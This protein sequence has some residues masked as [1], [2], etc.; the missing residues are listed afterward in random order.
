LTLID[1]AR[2]RVRNI[3]NKDRFSWLD[4]DRAS[5]LRLRE[6][7]TQ[8]YPMTGD[9]TQLGN[10][11]FPNALFPILR[12]YPVAISGGVEFHIDFEVELT[13]V[14]PQQIH[15]FEVDAKSVEWF[16]SHYGNRSDFLINHLGLSS[17]AEQLDVLGDINRAW[18]STVDKR[19]A[20]SS[21]QRWDVI[22]KVETTT[23]GHYCRQQG[24]SDI[25]MMKLDIEGFATRVI[26]STWDDGILPKTIVFEIERGTTENIFDYSD[27]L[28]SLLKRAGDLDYV[29]WHVPRKDGYSSF[30][31]DFILVLASELQSS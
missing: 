8:R 29:T 27:R 9:V 20:A 22:G 16:R 2:N 23:V 4:Q 6:Y 5:H 1:S 3:V 11:A 10:Y 17:K 25:G 21:N 26:H 30:S 18:S 31:T 19:L 13:E 7:L 28:F 15:F 24:I 12:K 14:V